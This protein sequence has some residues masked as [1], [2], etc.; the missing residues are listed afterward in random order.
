VT[1]RRKARE[2]VLKVLYMCECRDLTVDEAFAEMESIDREMENSDRDPDALNLKPFALGFT[3]KQK[4]FAL[5]LAQT[6]EGSKD[7]LNKHIKTVLE[8]WDFERV[9]RIDRIIMWIAISEMKVMLD[10]PSIVSVN[11]AIELAKK[12]SSSKSPAFIN[13]VLDAVARNMGVLR[14]NETGKAT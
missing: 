7:T 11:E 5:S 1:S 3:G 8:N 4:K 6:I 2:T 10:I 14:K 13:G 12:F 9:S